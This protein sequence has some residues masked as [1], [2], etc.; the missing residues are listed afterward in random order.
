MQLELSLVVPATGA[1]TDVVVDAPDGMMLRE[2]TPLLLNRVLTDRASAVLSIDGQALPPSAPLGVPPLVRGALLEL[3]AGL[4]GWGRERAVRVPCDA[5]VPRGRPAGRGV[6][7]VVP[8]VVRRRDDRVSRPRRGAVPQAARGR[9]R[10]SAGAHR[11]RLARR[12]GLRR[13]SRRGSTTAA[14]GRP[15]FTL[16]FV[17]RRGEGRVVQDRTVYVV[18][19]T[20]GSGKQEIPEWLRRALAPGP[21]VC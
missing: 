21:H 8:R 13:P 7:H 18:V 12:R 17:V 3:K 5:A 4:R 15:S 2:V 11:D 10:R 20:D 14:L 1:R 6:Q 9:P 19:A 16:E